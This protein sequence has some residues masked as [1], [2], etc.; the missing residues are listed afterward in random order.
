LSSTA[1]SLL[2][3]IVLLSLGG[4]VVLA[5]AQNTQPLQYPQPGQTTSR[6]PLGE[7]QQTD[8]DPTSRHALEEAARKRY[9]ERQTKMA[10]N[11]DKLL[12]L[13]QELDTEVEQG[14]PPVS[15]VKKADEIEK[16]AKSVKE[17]TLE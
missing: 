10:A 1:G 4:A 12:R 16:L 8:M 17:L 11:A 9:G 13:A 5:P 3:P 2:M 15:A 6:G 14:K 7:A